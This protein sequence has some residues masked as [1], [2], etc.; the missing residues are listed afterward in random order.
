MLP[1]RVIARAPALA[2]GVGGL[3][4]RAAR[5]VEAV[6][7]RVGGL[8]DEPRPL[9]AE[10]RAELY[11][12][13][14]DGLDLASIRVV[15][16]RSGLLEAS[17]RPVTLG[18]TIHLKGRTSPSLLVHEAVHVW[19]FHRLGARYVVDA[20]AGQLS[21]TGYDWR[22]AL[23]RG[24]P[25]WRALNLEAQAQCVQDLHAGGAF[26]PGPDEPAAPVVVD[27]VAYDDLAAEVAAALRGRPTDAAG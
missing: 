7:T 14:G 17:A 23:A 19:Q 9:T 3:V 18:D 5:V 26:A 8:Q 16:Q 20:V 11:F 27:G 24:T 21:P 15:P 13:F 1:L 22:A 10:Q 12:V 25:G 4:L 2:R 6:Q